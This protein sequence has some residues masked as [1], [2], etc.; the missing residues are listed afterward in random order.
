MNEHILHDDK[1]NAHPDELQ[2]S[3]SY[4]DDDLLSTKLGSAAAA[5]P[6]P[7]VSLKK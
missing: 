3:N 1:L 5:S 4:V 2:R 7:V 6:A